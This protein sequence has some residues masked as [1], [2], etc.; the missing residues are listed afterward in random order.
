MTG[1]TPTDAPPAEPGPLD[2]ELARLRLAQDVAGIGTW[3]WDLATGGLD[4]DEQCADLLGLYLA[5]A[6]RTIE[7]F[8]A[9]THPDDLEHVMALLHEAADTPGSL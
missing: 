1:S 6:P 3:D 5:E 7:D 4:W 2:T 9:L 8:E